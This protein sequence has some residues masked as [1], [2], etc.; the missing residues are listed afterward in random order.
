MPG[1]NQSLGE[2]ATF[3]FTKDFSLDNDHTSI[4]EMSKNKYIFNSFK[5]L[6]II[7]LLEGYW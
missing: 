2:M 3:P 1:E 4:K 5:S 6:Y 7:E